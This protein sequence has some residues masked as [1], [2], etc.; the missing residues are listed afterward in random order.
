MGIA[1]ERP[2]RRFDGIRIRRWL[3]PATLA[4]TIA[5]FGVLLVDGLITVH[6]DDQGL[7]DLLVYRAGGQAVLSG[8]SLY[9]ADFAAVNHAPNGL[10]FTYPPFAAVVFAPLALLT[11][12]VA[13]VV[14]VVVNVAAAITLFAI[15]AV[16]TQGKWERLRSRQA[17]TAPISVRTAVAIV[18]AAAVFVYSIPVQHNMI[19]GQVNL[20]LAAAVALDLLLPSTPWPRGLLVGIA[21]AVKLTPAVFVGYFLVTRQWRAMAVSLASAVLASAIGWLVAPSDTVRYWTSTAFDPARIGGLAYASNQSMRGVI[22][23]IPA[24]DGLS[25]VIWVVAAVLVVGLAIVAIEVSRRRGDPVAGML[26]AA[27]IG[28]LCS[29]VS[30]GHHWVWL[31]ATSVYFLMSWAAVGGVGNLAAGLVVAIVTRAAPWAHLPN[32]DQRERQWTPVQ[33]LLGST[34]ALTALVL[35]SLF[36]LGWPTQPSRRT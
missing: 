25:G 27:Y 6:S 17:L 7:I 14:M 33:H 5:L 12:G 10:S 23:R 13:K 4:I 31:S 30:W 9:A 26:S 34:W 29:P 21:F 18:A 11:T 22:E 15:V 2:A 35:L 32:S 19:Y 36:A 3:T 1:E 8:H 20:V 24:L 16:G 28:L